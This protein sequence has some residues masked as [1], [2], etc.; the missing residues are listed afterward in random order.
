M[1][2]SAHRFGFIALA[3]APNVGKSTLINRLVGAKVSIISRKPQTTRH[4]ILGIKTREDAQLVF[5]DTPGLHSAQNKNLNRML[6]RT[7]INSLSNVDIIVFMIDHRGWKPDLVNA[8]KKVTLSQAIEKQIP[9][10]LVI[11]KMDRFQDKTRLLPL[12]QQS[13]EL[14]NFLEIVPISARKMHDTEDFLS[15]L[16]K[17]LPVAPAGFPSDQITDRDNRFM[18]AELVRE[19]TFLLLG[20]ELP[21][22]SA[23][24]VTRFEHSDPEFWNIDMTIWVGKASQKSIVIGNRGSRLKAIGESSRKQIE[25]A[26]ETRVRLNLWVKQ[27]KGWRDNNSML[28]SLGYCE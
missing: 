10:I 21:Y 25:H 14:Y 7:A 6:N 27:R 24:E 17:H 19:Q 22:E 15:L 16:I 12:I 8:L 1:K 5:V 9:L 28:E 23:I 3:G 13:S 4:R 26:F 11:N 20:N 18:V 2:A